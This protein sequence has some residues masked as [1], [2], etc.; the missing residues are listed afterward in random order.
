MLALVGDI[1]SKKDISG[2]YNTLAVP[3]P[4]IDAYIYVVTKHVY[5]YFDQWTGEGS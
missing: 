3:T 1:T 2:K 4:S 5:I